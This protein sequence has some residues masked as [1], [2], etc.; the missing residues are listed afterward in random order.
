MDGALEAHREGAVVVPAQAVPAEVAVAG[1]CAQPVDYRT[2]RLRAGLPVPYVGAGDHLVDVPDEP[3]VL[4]DPSYDGLVVACVAQHAYR[5]A[6]VPEV[7]QRRCAPCCG[8]E[9]M[10]APQE[11]VLHPLGV[12]LASED[13]IEIGDHGIDRELH[14]AVGRLEC[15]LLL[16]V[17]AVDLLRIRA[18]IVRAERLEHGQDRA[19]RIHHKRAEHVEREEPAG[20][21]APVDERTLLHAHGMR[22]NPNIIVADGASMKCP[23]C[24][25]DN[26]PD[27]LFCENCDWRLDMEFK[28]ERATMAVQLSM[29]T[30]VLGVLSVICLVM[31]SGIAAAVLG[32]I[33]LVMGGY[34]VNAAR[35]QGAGKM[36]VAMAGIGLFLGLF[37]F[38]FGFFDVA[39]DL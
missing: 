37:G 28:P 11:A 26:P 8:C 6:H 36:Y 14:A 32:A 31:D 23:R 30:I 12:G 33:T 17:Y 4:Q 5:V 20:G 19:L 3:G 15:G 9:E 21:I 27:K 35:I 34:S 2:V 29:A 18:R 25:T 13:G 16:A 10:R 38:L 1:D 7:R 39:G 22:R 24:G